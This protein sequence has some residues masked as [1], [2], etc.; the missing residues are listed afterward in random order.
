MRNGYPVI[1]LNRKTWYLP[2]HGVNHASKTD[3]VRIVFD[4]SAN[5]GGTSLNNKLLS[6]ADLINQLAWGTNKIPHWGSSLYG[7]H[8]GNVLSSAS[9]QGIEKCFKVPLVGR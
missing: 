5:Y 2:H 4:C 3:K 1:Q 8:R 9:S 7:W 6:G